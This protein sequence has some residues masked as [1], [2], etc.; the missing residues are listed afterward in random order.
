MGSALAM[1]R[2][3]LGSQIRRAL[4]INKVA[5]EQQIGASQPVTNSSFHQNGLDARGHQTSLVGDAL[6]T[7]GHKKK[8][9]ET[10]PGF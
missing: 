4:W 9:R 1:V 2:L 3:V 8:C 7:R 10:R 6:S 5:T